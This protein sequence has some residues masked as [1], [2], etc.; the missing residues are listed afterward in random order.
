MRRDAQQPFTPRQRSRVQPAIPGGGKPFARL[1]GS[2]PEAST[3]RTI[4]GPV[5][6]PSQQPPLPVASTQTTEILRSTVRTTAIR[7]VSMDGSSSLGPASARSSWAE[8]PQRQP[9]F[10]VGYSW[11]SLFGL[12]QSGQLKVVL[13]ASGHEPSLVTFGS[14]GRGQDGGYIEFDPDE[15]RG[16]LEIIV[17]SGS[18]TVAGGVIPVEELWQLAKAP[19]RPCY[20][21][22][23]TKPK[24]HSLVDKLARAFSG[25]SIAESEPLY[26]NI[27][28]YD[29]CLAAAI[30]DQKKGRSDLHITGKWR[31][32]LDAFAE[33][34]GVRTI[35]ATLAYLDWVVGPDVISC[36]SDCL[37]TLIDKVE[38]LKA[39]Q[40]GSAQHPQDQAILGLMVEEAALLRLIEEAVKN[41]LTRCFQKYHAVSDRAPTGILEGDMANPESPS[42]IL[43][44]AVKLADVLKQDLK[45]NMELWL[46]DCLQVAAVR[47]FEAVNATC[48]RNVR[49]LPGPQQTQC[50]LFTSRDSAAG[51]QGYQLS[52]DVDAVIY[53]VDRAD[54]SP[55][56]QAAYAQLEGLCQAIVSE[57]QSD[58]ELH[59]TG[60][61]PQPIQ[62]HQI[63]SA[64]YCKLF[65]G[66]LKRVLD[67]NSPPEPS[68]AAINLMLGVGKFEVRRLPFASVTQEFIN[69]YGMRPSS[70]PGSEVDAY[71]IFLPY[72]QH[73]VEGSQAKLLQTCQAFEGSGGSGPLSYVAGEETGH[74]VI[75]PFLI[76]MLQNIQTEIQ[77]YER[78]VNYWP[79]YAPMLEEAVCA[80]LRAVTAAVTRQCGIMPARRETMLA[81]SCNRGFAGFE[82]PVFQW[83]QPPQAIGFPIIS[84]PTRAPPLSSSKSILPFEAVLLNSLRRLLTFVPQT[85]DVLT[86]WARTTADSPGRE[87][88]P[89]PNQSPTKIPIEQEGKGPKRGALFNQLVKELR[90]EYAAAVTVCA[91]RIHSAL[92]DHRCSIRAALEKYG[93][94]NDSAVLMEQMHP[95]LEA[96]EDVLANLFK[97]VD[98]RVYISVGRGLWDCTSQDVYEYLEGLQ[99]GLGL[100]RGAWRGRQNSKAVMDVID[101]FFSATFSATLMHGCQP[102]DLDQPL[103]SDKTHKLLAENT[104]A[105][106]MSYTVY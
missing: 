22:Q 99:E 85:N 14:N 55:G 20:S 13:Q 51:V 53:N 31:W 4:S 23:R 88:L 103:H 11:K 52:Q 102:K 101:N 68:S 39:V 9:P 45:P 26:G 60:V 16:R 77:R 49:G 75:A 65:L 95:T 37:K 19:A 47:R 80:V 33:T 36:T 72:V 74:G 28:A 59:D 84:Q 58:L 69:F 66:K 97:V 67:C 87:R 41:M 93:I 81:S 48:E 70:G 2:A 50:N 61:F 89:T 15:T 18:R 82:K 29:S 92:A 10:K 43:R 35:Y 21:P 78:L 83:Q 56:F 34:Y 62:L 104:T 76:E 17:Q 7:L 46:T 79:V 38:H 91:Q 64:E 24:T 8:P 40:D 71:N 90:S 44:H 1:H 5:L 94:I 25:Q 27:W 106:N 73:W 12:Q 32:L 98:N 86:A 6:L 54:D 96:V 30:R 105:I 100:N 57:L 42:S 3:T 63:T